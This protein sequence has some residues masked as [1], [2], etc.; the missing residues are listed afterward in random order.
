MMYEDI[1][2]TCKECG[3]SFQFTAGEQ[4][5][6]AAK[7]FSNHPLRCKECRTRRRRE[8]YAGIC[9]ACGKEARVPFLPKEDRPLYCAECYAQIKAEREGNRI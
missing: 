6:Y 9:A 3:K 2:L 7:G 1:T 4:E 8:A 5:F